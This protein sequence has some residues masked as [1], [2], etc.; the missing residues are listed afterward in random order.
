MLLEFL[1]P[2]LISVLKIFVAIFAVALISTATSALESNLPYLVLDRTGAEIAKVE[3]YSGALYSDGAAGVPVVSKSGK[4]LQGI[5]DLNGKF[6]VP[7]TCKFCDGFQEGLAWIE[8]SNSEKGYILPTGEFA[9]KLPKVSSGLPFSEGLAP[10]LI[11]KPPNYYGPWGYVDTFGKMIIPAIYREAHPFHEGRAA[12]RC[13]V[14][15][16]F[17]DKKGKQVGSDFAWAGDFS[18]GLAPVY[19]KVP[20][21]YGGRHGVDDGFTG[22]GYVNRQGQMAISP[23]YCQVGKFSEGLA[24]VKQGHKWG[25]IDTS[26]KMV[27]AAQFDEVFTFS[28]GLCPA[29]NT[30]EKWGYIDKTGVFAIPPQFEQAAEFSDGLGRVQLSGKFGFL[31]KDGHF[32]I[33]PIYKTCGVFRSGRVFALKGQ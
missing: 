9:F 18:A 12:V 29:H 28:D 22:G 2:G 3:M 19:F 27:I 16:R 30:G 33:P 24:A 10:V 8:R 1:R 7:P 6:I 4:Y 17:I 11:R 15:Y 13:D 5:V 23:A 25:F 31:G 14:D 26:G 20:G 21:C 32:V